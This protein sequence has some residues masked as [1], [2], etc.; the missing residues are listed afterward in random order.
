MTCLYFT[1]LQTLSPLASLSMAPTFF[2]PLSP[3]ERAWHAA[4]ISA[5]QGARDFAALNEIDH[6]NRF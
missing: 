3:A 1:T 4:R 2:S 6:M 5:F